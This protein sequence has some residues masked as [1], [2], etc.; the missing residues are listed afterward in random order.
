[1]PLKLAPVNRRI[2]LILMAWGFGST[3]HN[4]ERF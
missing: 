1:M 3:H 4:A 2:L